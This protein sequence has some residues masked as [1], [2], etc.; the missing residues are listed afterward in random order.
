MPEQWEMKKLNERHREIARRT[1]KGESQIS[2]SG[3]LGMTPQA[4]YLIT[5][6]DL[7]VNEMERLRGRVEEELVEKA[8]EPLDRAR[9]LLTAASE[10]A[11]QATINIM[12]DID[13]KPTVRLSAAKDIL[14]RVGVVKRTEHVEGSL[15]LSFEQTNNLFEAVRESGGEVLELATISV[16]KEGKAL[17]TRTRSAESLLPSEGHPGV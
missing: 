10:N 6:S 9:K 16:D 4:L 15:V 5:S 2:I 17:P 3:A 11:A 7:F 12:E 14:D 8:G 13:L 1:L